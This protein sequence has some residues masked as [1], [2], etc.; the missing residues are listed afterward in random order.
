MSAYQQLFS[1]PLL[2]HPGNE[3]KDTV[4]LKVA[5]VD[6]KKGGRL[7]MDPV[8]HEL[9]T[10]LSRS[11]AMTITN[12]H[13]SEPMFC[14]LYSAQAFGKLMEAKVAGGVA[15]ADVTHQLESVAESVPPAHP[16]K[17]FWKTLDELVA[18]GKG[19]T[20]QSTS[21]FTSPRHRPS[22][23][24]GSGHLS[25]ASIIGQSPGPSTSF[26]KY[27]F[28]FFARTMPLRNLN[29]A[30]LAQVADLDPSTSSQIV[31]S[32]PGKGRKKTPSRHSGFQRRSGVKKVTGVQD[33][34]KRRKDD[35]DNDKPSTS[36]YR[37][38]KGP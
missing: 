8:A 5:L 2:A 33:P 15:F 25:T 34:S 28:S 16:T 7:T 26:V 29:A 6:E 22:S 35:D 3:R 17:E 31:P 18:R 12:E 32:T 10:R 30:H 38:A 37:L 24:I 20:D 4:Y 1:H 14:I 23:S 21:P 27:I 11:H 19:P 36:T 9:S 13:P